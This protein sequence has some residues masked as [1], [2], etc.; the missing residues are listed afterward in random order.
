MTDNVYAAGCA[1]GGTIERGI[2]LR[3]WLAAKA[4]A[5]LVHHDWAPQ[6]L[7]S[8]AYEHADAMLK[9]RDK[10]RLPRETEGGHK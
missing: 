7:A 4:M 10:S 9:A 6:L 1:P 5:T 2:S 8:L 3:D